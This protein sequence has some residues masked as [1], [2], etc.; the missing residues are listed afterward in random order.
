M[1][2]KNVAIDFRQSSELYEL[3]F[4]S[5]FMFQAENCEERHLHRAEMSGFS[6]PE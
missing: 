5:M 4:L 1:A 3:S 6:A 2:T